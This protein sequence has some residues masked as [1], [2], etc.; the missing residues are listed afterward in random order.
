MY[1]SDIR[2]HFKINEVYQGLAKAEGIMY[3]D[4]KAL[5][6][7][8]EVKDSMFGVIKS[9]PK[10]LVI[11]IALISNVRFSS[12]FLLSRFKFDVNDLKLLSK[13]P[14]A[15]EG[16]VKLAIKRRNKEAGFALASFLNGDDMGK[17]LGSGN[18]QDPFLR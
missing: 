15:K 12:N 8:Y 2:L 7:E 10:K 17:D 6:L 14:G 3:T 18:F 11:P 1:V 5:I 13:F 16:R 9:D 4:E